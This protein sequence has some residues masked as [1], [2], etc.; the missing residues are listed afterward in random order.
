MVRIGIAMRCNRCLR[1]L[2][3][4][5]SSNMDPCHMEKG[6]T[7]GVSCV[8]RRCLVSVHLRVRF[9]LGQPR[10]DEV[11]EGGLDY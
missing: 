8:S 7:F 6:L 1:T 10:N 2:I 3:V 5:C 11:A 9:R 4:R